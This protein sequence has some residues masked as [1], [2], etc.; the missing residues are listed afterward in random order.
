MKINN[1]KYSVSIVGFRDAH[2]RVWGVNPFHFLSKLQFRGHLGG[3][4]G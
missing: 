1:R 3:S 4:V 2:K